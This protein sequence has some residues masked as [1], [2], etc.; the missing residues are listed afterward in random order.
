MGGSP[1]SPKPCCAPHGPLRAAPFPRAVVRAT[2]S[3]TP[4]ILKVLG[5]KLSKIKTE[6]GEADFTDVI[7]S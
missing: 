3:D 1:V 4:V 7:L 2:R 6:T 5:A